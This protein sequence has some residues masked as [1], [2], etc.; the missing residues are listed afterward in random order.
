[1]AVFLFPTI[2]DYL[3]V[4]IAQYKLCLNKYHE[5]LKIVRILMYFEFNHDNQ[6]TLFTDSQKLLLI[7]NILVIRLLMLILIL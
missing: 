3:R 5:I 2:I 7:S 6:Y 1:M 4:Y